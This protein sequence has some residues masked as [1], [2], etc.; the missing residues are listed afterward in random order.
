MLFFTNDYGCGAHPKI[1]E[2]LMETNMEPLS[3]YGSDRYTKKAE[4]KI[5]SLCRLEKGNVY[6]MTGG[7]QTNSIIITALL[8][9]WEGVLAAETGH[10]STHE[11]GAVET[12]GHKVLALPQENGK[13]KAADIQAYIENFYND[14]TYDHMVFPG[15]VY[16]SYPT[17]YGTLYTKEELEQISSVCRS[18]KIP[19]FIDG[20]R[21]I[22]G[23]SAGDITL[24]EIAKLADVF[25]IG[26][27]KAGALI[28]EAVVFPQGM[29]PHFVT[30]AKQHGALLAKGRVLGVQF[31]ALF[32]GGLYKE[33]G[34]YTIG[35]SRRL[36]SGLLEKKYRLFVDSPTNQQFVILSNKQ[37]E[38]LKSKVAFQTWGETDENHKVIRLVVSW[39]TTEQD[40]DELLSFLPG[41]I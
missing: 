26:G 41:S 40:V 19:L 37:A 15:M 13:L 1:L 4:E 10:I 39:S 38:A 30:F 21:L 22:Y 34:D 16:I 29:P 17:E 7:T 25:Y 33:I 31:D 11:A 32:T 9:P 28:G 23:L 2:R 27:T 18:H 35:L 5:L 8:R 3:G 36:K 6:F 14:E 20:A 24:P 12:L